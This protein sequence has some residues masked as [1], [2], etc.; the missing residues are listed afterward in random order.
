MRSEGTMTL[1]AQMAIRSQHLKFLEASG[2][3]AFPAQPP[4]RTATNAIIRQRAQ[5]LIVGKQPIHIVG[6]VTAIRNFGKISFVRV[7]DGSGTEDKQNPQRGDLQIM[8]SDQTPAELF[9]LF[10][11]GG[12]LGDI[13]AVTGSLTESKTGEL[14][15]NVED[16]HMLAKALRPPPGVQQG[17]HQ[18][19]T[20]IARKQRY[21]DLMASSDSRE[22]F[23][24]R[25]KIVQMMRQRFMELGNLEVNT[26]ILDIIYGGAAAQPFTT[27][28]NALDQAMFLRISNELY[29]KRL[30]VGMLN[31]GEGGVFE[32]SVDFR[33]EG[34]DATHHPE[35]T[36]VELYMP[37]RDYN[38][39]MDMTESLYRDIVQKTKGKLQVDYQNKTVDFNNWR[40]VRVYDG[41][42]EVLGINPRTISIDDINQL[43]QTYGINK[44]QE[45]GVILLEIFEKAV[46]PTYGPDPLF[47]LDYPKITSPLTK[48]NRNDPELAERFELII[49]GMEVGNCY[50]ELNDPRDQRERFEKEKSKRAHGDIDAQLEDADF[51]E[52]M[53]H[54]L[55]PMGGIGLSIDRLTMILTNQPHIQDVILFPHQ[56][57]P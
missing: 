5:E 49:A 39:M 21:I 18:I 44:N 43:A 3:D 27:H 38:F 29:L 19:D 54:G 16:W 6:R 31:D 25:A 8:F 15:V 10:K 2:I 34:M 4:L 24:T 36:Q 35:F 28:H 17:A 52:A 22:R 30:I 42:Q 47:V 14:T 55:P 26:P 57:K 41:L 56:R 23:R 20:A 12:D 37:Y 48:A 13:V 46:L 32:F 40:K 9:N 1:A 7:D 53:E 33:N 50:T 45:R 11:G 51:I